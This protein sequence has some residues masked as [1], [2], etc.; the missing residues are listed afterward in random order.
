M[1]PRPFLKWAGGKTQLLADLLPL[2][3]EQFDT[4]YE[5]F[6]GGGAVFFALAREKRF[7]QAVLSDSNPELVNAYVA[8]RDDLGKVLSL[9]RRHAR[10]HCE[11]YYYEVRISSPRGSAQRAARTIYL[12][13]TCFNGLYRVNRLGGFNVPFGDYKNPPIVDAENLEAVSIALQ[14][15]QLSCQDFG[16]AIAQAAANLKRI[17]VYFDPPYLPVASGSFVSYDRMPFGKEEH[18]RLADGF[19]ALADLEVHVVLTNSSCDETYRLY[20]GL[21]IENV[22]SRRSINRDGKARG[23]VQ[24]VIV[25]SKGR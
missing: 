1:I 10:K 17:A 8:V 6:L 15:V 9:L 11:Q 18:Q 13:K 5:P 16:M 25:F 2:F 21:G 12:N 4:Y 7:G 22:S 14:G 3:P 19:R 23:A 20:G 24:D